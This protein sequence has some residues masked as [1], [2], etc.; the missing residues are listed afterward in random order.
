MADSTSD[1]VPEEEDFR[2]F[3]NDRTPW[4]PEDIARLEAFCEEAPHWIFNGTPDVPEDD[5]EFLRRMAEEFG[6]KE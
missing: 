3:V 5:P 1:G 6:H 4:T 2:P